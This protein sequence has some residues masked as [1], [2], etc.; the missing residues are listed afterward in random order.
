MKGDRR[1]S[2]YIIEISLFFSTIYYCCELF[3]ILNLSYQIFRSILYVNMVEEKKNYKKTYV[4]I[5]YLK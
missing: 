2:V 3:T 1:L 5:E 4:R